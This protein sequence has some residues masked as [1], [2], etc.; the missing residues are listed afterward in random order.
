MQSQDLCVTIFLFLHRGIELQEWKQHDVRRL[1]IKRS[2]VSKNQVFVGQPREKWS[3]IAAIEA[4]TVPRS[5]AVFHHN[6]VWVLA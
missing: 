4:A 5:L 1:A 6:L 3:I 2:R